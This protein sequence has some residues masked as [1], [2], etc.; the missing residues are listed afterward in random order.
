MNFEKSEI[1]DQRSEQNSQ[2]SILNPVKGR[3]PNEALRPQ[4]SVE[5]HIEEL[6]LHGFAPGDRFAVGDAVESELARLLHEQG[7]PISLRFRNA[8]DEIRNATFNATHNA[9]P[10]TIGRQISQA[11]YQGFGK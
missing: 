8:T 6:V 7:I 11:V 3:G 2:L 5:L 4:P 1:R 10:S 9:K